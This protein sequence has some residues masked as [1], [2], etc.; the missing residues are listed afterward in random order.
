MKTKLYANPFCLAFGHNFFRLKN[1][2]TKKQE[3]V[4]KSC[5]HYFKYN[6]NGKIIEIPYKPG[7]FFTK[8][9]NLSAKNQ[10]KASILSSYYNL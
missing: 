9:K 3:I 5:K 1:P 6:I 4:C 2:V 8:L 10:I 7:K